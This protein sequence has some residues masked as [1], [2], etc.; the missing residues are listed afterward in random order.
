VC[1]SDFISSK[2]NISRLTADVDGALAP[3]RMTIHDTGLQS[4]SIGDRLWI[5]WELV[6][7][8]AEFQRLQNA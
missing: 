6:N 3:R 1:K 8:D 4:Y 2:L 7:N 5:D